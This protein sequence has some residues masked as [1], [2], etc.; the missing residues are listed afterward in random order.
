MWSRRLPSTIMSLMAWHRA[1]MRGENPPRHD[2]MPECGWYRMQAVKNGP[3]VPVLIWCSQITDES[4]E[5]SEPETMHADAFGEQKDP[6]EI[7]TWLTPISRADY[8]DLVRFRTDTE[9]RISSRKPIDLS[10]MP[11]PPGGWGR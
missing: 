2:G 7:W 6:E 10:A 8:D 11:T 5:L 1:A 9:H 3:W 4:G